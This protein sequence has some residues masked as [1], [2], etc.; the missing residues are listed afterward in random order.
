MAYWGPGGGGGFIGF[1][2]SPCSAAGGPLSWR[3]LG[4]SPFAQAPGSSQHSHLLC[5]HLQLQW[6]V[7]RTI[8]G[9]GTDD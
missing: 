2:L 5:G 3:R 7:N 6:T 8:T 1:A 4:R 9:A